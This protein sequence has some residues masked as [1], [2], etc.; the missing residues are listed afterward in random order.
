MER[1]DE[2]IGKIIEKK[3]QRENKIINQ[4]PEKILRYF[5]IV[6]RKSERYWN[7]LINA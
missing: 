3:Q 7:E 1:I 6:S 2:Y 4:P 5:K